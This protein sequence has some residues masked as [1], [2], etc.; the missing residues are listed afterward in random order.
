MS[1]DI[2]LYQVFSVFFMK[3]VFLFNLKVQLK[4]DN[5]S[6]NSYAVNFGGLHVHQKS[7]LI[8][9][10]MNSL[11]EYSSQYFVLM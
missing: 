6:S 5:P 4:E 7:H 10:H 9:V 2:Q 1:P 8:Y 11:K 3:P